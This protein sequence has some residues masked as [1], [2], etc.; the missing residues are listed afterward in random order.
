M[1]GQGIRKAGCVTKR[2]VGT[3][4]IDNLDIADPS[5][6]SAQ[7]N[8]LFPV[9]LVSPAKVVDDIGHR[10]FGD[11]MAAVV[12]QRVVLDDTAVFVFSLGRAQI[13]NCLLS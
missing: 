11:R 9:N 3:E 10:L 2:F 1:Q 4:A 12:G 5:Y 7:A 13:H 8:Q 6:G